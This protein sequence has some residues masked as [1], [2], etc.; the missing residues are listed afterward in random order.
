MQMPEPEIGHPLL[1]TPGD[2][3]SGIWALQTHDVFGAARLTLLP[4]LIGLI[5]TN[6]PH[7]AFVAAPTWWLV[8]LHILRGK[9]AMAALKGMA[10][11]AASEY[12]RV[13]ERARLNNYVY[14]MDPALSVSQV[15]ASDG[16]DG[17]EITTHGSV[18]TALFGPNGVLEGASG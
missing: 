5:T 8:L 9:G 3:S 18:A 10:Q 17:I 7:G 15:V 11:M 13:S 6:I 4:T 14:W 1:A 2:P 16:P 12:E